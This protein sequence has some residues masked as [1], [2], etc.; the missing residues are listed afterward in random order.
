MLGYLLGD[1][2]NMPHFVFNGTMQECICAYAIYNYNYSEVFKRAC[3]AMET[4]DQ[5]LELYSEFYNDSIDLVIEMD[6][7]QIQHAS[8]LEKIN[9]KET[10]EGYSNKA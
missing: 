3:L 6:A 7:G 2:S 5:C 4:L 1:C 9:A 10:I 8:S